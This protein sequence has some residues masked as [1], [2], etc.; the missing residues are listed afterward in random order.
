MCCAATM[1]SD[2]VRITCMLG[3]GRPSARAALCAEVLGAGGGLPDLGDVMHDRDC[4]RCFVLTFFWPSMPSKACAG[5][6][7][8]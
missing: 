8:S 1:A 3:A 6:T 2:R 7:R 4:K 5:T